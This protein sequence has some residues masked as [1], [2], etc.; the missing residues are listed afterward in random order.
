VE[1]GRYP[2]FRSDGRLPSSPE[3]MDEFASVLAACPR[4]PTRGQQKAM[5]APRDSEFGGEAE[6]AARLRRALVRVRE[7]RR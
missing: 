2:L 5:H 3:Q 7:R 1:A 4:P 6:V